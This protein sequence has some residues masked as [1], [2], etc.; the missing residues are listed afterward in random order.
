MAAAARGTGGRTVAEP[1]VIALWTVGHSVTQP[2]GMDT[3]VGASTAV[4]AWTSVPTTPELVLVT[5]T[6]VHS[7]AARVHW[8]TEEMFSRTREVCL[9]AAAR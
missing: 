5:W 9:G 8:E 4:E 3:D 1:L 7:V 2:A 6:I